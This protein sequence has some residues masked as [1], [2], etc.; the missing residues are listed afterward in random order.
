[1]C[2]SDLAAIVATFAAWRS[3][4][5]AAALALLLVLRA[6]RTG[7][8][9][10]P[11]GTHP[12]DWAVV[13]ALAGFGFLVNLG[14]FTA[15]ARMSIGLALLAF[16]TYP[17]MIGIVG[18]LFLGLLPGG[19]YYW[20]YRRNGG[21][22]PEDRDD[23]TIAELALEHGTRVG[24][25]QIRNQRPGIGRDL[26]GRRQHG[27]RQQDRRHADRRGDAHV[28]RC[29]D[30]GTTTVV[31]DRQRDSRDHHEEGRLDQTAHE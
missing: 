26:P 8:P 13:G 15:F 24:G 14:L 6:L 16:Y 18:A 23:A 30:A 7:G 27:D 22:R 29:D 21:N 5:G 28:P 17:V 11:A 25:D 3:A 1:M 2:S 19:Y 12:R 4:T 20:W 10:V 31:G 9:I